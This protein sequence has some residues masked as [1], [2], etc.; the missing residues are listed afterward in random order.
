MVDPGQRQ[1]YWTDYDPSYSG[2]IRVPLEAMRKLPFTER[3]IIA[4]RAAM[5]IAPGAVCNLGAGISTG[6]SAVAAE[7]GFLDRIVLT[8]EQGYIGGAPITGPDSG[9]AQNYDAMVDQPYQFD[10]YD[11][12]GLDIAFLSFAEVD[13]G[14]NVN[15]SRFGDTI[16]GIGGF[17]NISQNARKVV[18]SGTFTAGGLEIRCEGGKLRIVTEGRNRKFVQAVEQ[19]CYNGAFA[20][21]EG[22]DAVFV[23]ERAVFRVGRSGLELSEIAPGVD[24]ERDVFAHMA[25]RPSVAP[26]LKLMDARLFSPAPMDLKRDVLSKPLGTRQ[27]RR[28]L[29]EQAAA[30]AAE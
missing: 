23:T 30:L 18:F 21:S 25:F 5:E 29:E 8:N 26:D 28:R 6:V 14:G 12:G 27:P 1:T 7:E 3:K 4:R 15:V 22:R 10:F 16:V 13:A 9:G 24:M 2:E 11:G 19:I 20:R 17:V